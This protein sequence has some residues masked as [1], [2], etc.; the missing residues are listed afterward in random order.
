MNGDTE[1][2]PSPPV[3]RLRKLGKNILFSLIIIIGFFAGL[4]LILAL[5]GVKPLLSTEDPLVG[6]AGNVPLY[7]EE[8]QADGSIMMKTASNK[9]YLFNDQQFPLIKGKNTYRIFCMGGSTTFGRPYTDK[10]SFCGWLHQYLRAVAPERNWE[11]INAGGVSYASYR[12][13]K[14]M[15][16][17]SRYQPDLFIVYTGQNE[18]LEQRSYGKLIDMPEWALNLDAL[19]SKTRTY[20]AIKDAIDYLNPSS[21]KHAR[22]RYKLSGEVDDIL[23]HTAGPVTYHRNNRLKQQ[24]VTHFRLNLERMIK[25]AHKANAGIIFVTPAVNLKD[26]SPFKSE[27]RHGLSPQEL[28]DWENLFQRGAAAQEKGEMDQALNLYRQALTIDDRYAELHYRIGRVLY[29]LKRYD[30]AEGEFWRAVDEDIAPLRALYTI[31]QIVP[32]I[33]ASN[34]VPDID[35]P[36]ILRHAYLQKYDNAI[37]GNEYFIDSVHPTIE[38]YRLLGTALLEQLSKQ[39]L[40]PAVDIAHDPRIVTVNER[41][42]ASLNSNDHARA[43]AQLGKLMDWAGKFEEANNLFLE[44]I[45]LR[46]SDPVLFSLIAKTSLKRHKPDEAIDYLTRAVTINPNMAW[47]QEALANV[48]SSQG[49]KKEAIAHYEASLRAKPDAAITH[50]ELAM[51]LAD[52]GQNDRALQEFHESIRLQP[53]NEQIRYNQIVF[54]IRLRHYEEALNQ[55]QELLRIN[56]KN[57]L[58]IDSLG[59]ILA[60]Q[61]KYDDAIVQ[62]NEALRIN[63]KYDTAQE[64]LKEAMKL[65]DKAMAGRPLNILPST[66]ALQSQAPPTKD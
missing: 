28:H 12:V 19:A 38:G 8:P 3:A 62:F 34:D 11:V 24:I 40:V 47:E 30:E 41:V 46:G 58:A 9:L 52:L 18:F 14:L 60:N 50:N 22:E 64:N 25:I 5:F 55:I 43:L 31:T 16:D 59:V 4:E 51:T 21:M 63:P 45:K 6:F 44:A 57:V 61:G 42:M 37:F 29:A 54:L 20:V 49:R 32:E 23:D 17:M 10:T 56:P 7:V 2:T 39:G 66:G 13:A 65:R 26:M 1:I 33:A 35:F 53:T 27:H 36:G 48:L 15:E